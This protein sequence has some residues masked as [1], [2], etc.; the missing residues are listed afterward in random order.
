MICIR[1]Q[2]KF[3]ALFRLMVLAKRRTGSGT[4]L[5]RKK[6]SG[7]LWNTRG[8][9]CGSPFEPRHK[10]WLRARARAIGTN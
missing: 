5:V 4:R 9:Y 2:I 7:H 6:L 3:L 1:T 10:E 8:I